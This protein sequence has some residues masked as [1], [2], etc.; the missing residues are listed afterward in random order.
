MYDTQSM[1]DIPVGSIL[2]GG[3]S[4]AKQ[5]WRPISTQCIDAYDVLIVLLRY[6]ISMSN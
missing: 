3:A 5:V 1:I 4:L 2:S 6:L